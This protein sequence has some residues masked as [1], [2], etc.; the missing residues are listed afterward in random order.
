MK[1]LWIAIVAIS[2]AAC[3]A[4]DP[5]LSEAECDKI[6]GT[7]KEQGSGHLSGATHR[8]CVKPGAT[9]QSF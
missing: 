7:M 2:L 1:Y 8:T 4:F 6:G 5:I 3:S 9:V